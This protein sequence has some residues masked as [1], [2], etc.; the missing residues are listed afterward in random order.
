MVTYAERPWVKRYDAGVPASLEPYPEIPLYQMLTDSARKA[1]NSVALV[2]SAHL[3]VLGR[4]GSE[5]TYAQVDQQTDAFAA[6]L[7]DLGL[8]KGDRVA[9]VMPNVAAFI[10]AYFGV[11][12]AGGVVSGRTPPTPP[13][14]CASR[15]TTATPNSS[16]R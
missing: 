15:S 4:V 7:I 9:I 1:P 3:P 2:T 6:A 12:K 13:R 10:I 14:S 11:L 5:L 8:K 16:S